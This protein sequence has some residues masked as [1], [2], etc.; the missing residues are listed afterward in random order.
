MRKGNVENTVGKEKKGA[1]TR[2]ISSVHSCGY[3]SSSRVAPSGATEQRI[4]KYLMSFY[5]LC[6][7]TLS[8]R[9]PVTI[10]LV[11]PAFSVSLE[12]K[13]YL[14]LSAAKVALKIRW[15]RP[16]SRQGWWRARGPGDGMCLMDCCQNTLKK[17]DKQITS[18][19]TFLRENTKIIQDILI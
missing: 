19:G 2:E 15:K 6:L 11:L 8:I 9:Q 12:R 18:A 17:G 3:I 13:G 5:P 16:D 4:R 1:E 14:S 10:K 7:C